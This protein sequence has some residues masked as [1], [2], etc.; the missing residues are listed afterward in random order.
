MC[1]RDRDHI[2]PV[3]VYLPGCPPRPEMLLDA[4]LELHEKIKSTPLG[5]NRDRAEREQEELALT[6][7]PGHQRRGLLR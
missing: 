6:A 1:I 5:V 4:I 2:I 3:D 7:V